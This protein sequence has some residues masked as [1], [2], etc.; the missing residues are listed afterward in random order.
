MVEQA[1]AQ[2][3]LPPCAVRGPKRPPCGEI[4]RRIMR[5]WDAW[6]DGFEVVGASRDGG[7]AGRVASCH[8]RHGR[9]LSVEWGGA[10]A[11]ELGQQEACSHSR[12]D[13]GEDGSATREPCWSGENGL[14]GRIAWRGRSGMP[15]SVWRSRS[16]LGFQQAVAWEQRPTG[17]SATATAGPVSTP[18]PC[19]RNELL[20]GLG[21]SACVLGKAD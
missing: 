13:S 9:Q 11:V 16:R 10:R 20:P 19:M 1:D 5:D 12:S 14:C 18:A 15:A 3:S 6:S 8:R 21:E 2:G 7:W 4:E 17:S